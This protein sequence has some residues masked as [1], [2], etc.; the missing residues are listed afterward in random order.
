MIPKIFRSCEL[1]LITPCFCAGA[2]QTAPELRAASFRGELRWWFRCLGGTREQEQAVFGGIYGEC[3]ASAVALLVVNIKPSPTDF[4][5]SFEQPNIKI[6]NSSYITY[7]LSANEKNFDA[8]KIVRSD[9]YLPP[10]KKFTLELRQVKDINPAN[11]ELLSL[12]WDCLCNLGA[13]GARKTR[14]L[15]AYA[16]V[17]TDEQK[18]LELLN[19]NIVKKNFNFRLFDK[20]EYGNFGDG[21]VTTQLL[22]DCAQKLKEYRKNLGIHPTLSKGQSAKKGSH[23]GTSALGN[24]IGERQSSAVRFRP[25]LIENKLK[26]CILKA[27]DFTLGAKAREHNFTNL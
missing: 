4:R 23:Y 7:F 24:A 19:N 14:A 16:P 11:M 17:K 15:G 27:P 10:K 5:W 6:A 26:L 22:S 8:T 1:Q 25:V 3:Q 13:I 12:A 9:A 18:V 20:K 2:D 21:S